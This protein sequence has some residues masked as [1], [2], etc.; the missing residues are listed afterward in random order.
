MCDQD[1][2]NLLAKVTRITRMCHLLC[3]QSGLGLKLEVQDG[4]CLLYF[5]LLA[6]ATMI[7]RMFHLLFGQSGLGVD[8]F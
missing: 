5:Q 8:L 1:L 3:G 2:L 6:K 7:A 4:G